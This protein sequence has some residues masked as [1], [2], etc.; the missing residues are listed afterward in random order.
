MATTE[1]KTETCDFRLT[2]PCKDRKGVTDAELGYLTMVGNLPY[3]ACDDCVEELITR[4]A[5]KLERTLS[6]RGDSVA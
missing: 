6:A 1:L 3:F 4:I 2:Q 5:L